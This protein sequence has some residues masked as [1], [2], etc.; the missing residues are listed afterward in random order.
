MVL[1]L[2]TFDEYTAYLIDLNGQYSKRLN[3]NYAECTE[4]YYSCH[5]TFKGQHWLFGGR[6]LNRQ[7]SVVDGC[8]L[9]RHSDLPFSFHTGACGNYELEKNIILLCFDYYGKQTCRTFDGQ[10]YEDSVSSNREHYYSRLGNYKGEP[11][12]VGDLYDADNPVEIMKNKNEIFEWKRVQDFP[13]ADRLRAYSI[14]STPSS[15]IIFGGLSSSGDQD[16]V[17]QYSQVQGQD[18][19]TLIGNLEKAR[20]GHSA[21]YKDDIA[22]IVGG[23]DGK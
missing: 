22:L 20:R 8:G 17:A 19:W 21:I 16:L 7:V 3:F 14:I 6:G 13:F 18:Q 23:Y 9:R 4:V 1:A 12:V 10:K 2:S 15:V 11:F 5:V